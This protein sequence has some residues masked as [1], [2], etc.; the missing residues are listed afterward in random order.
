MFCGECGTRNPDISEVCTNCGKPLRK[1][2][3]L[4]QPAPSAD[5]TRPAVQPAAAALLAKRK[6]N[7]IGIGSLI[8]GILSWVILT[9]LLAIVAIILGVFSLY[10]TKK[11]TGKIA[12]SAI[13]GIVIAGTAVVVSLLLS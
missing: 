3:P 10:K 2:Q 7:W 4:V 9:T 12:F 6:R 13:A 1:S 8:L 5:S 11:E